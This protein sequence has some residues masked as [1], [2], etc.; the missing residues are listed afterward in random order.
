MLLSPQ[1]VPPFVEASAY[2]ALY[3]YSWSRIK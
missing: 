2:S 3:S 1:L